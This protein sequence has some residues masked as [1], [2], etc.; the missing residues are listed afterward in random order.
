MTDDR[1]FAGL[2]SGVEHSVDELTDAI[3]GCFRAEIPAYAPLPSEQLEPGVRSNIQ[4]ALDAL[5]R[6]WEPT[7][8]EI[9]ASR[10]LGEE[11]ARQGVPLEALLRAHRI[12]VR[13]VLARVQS[14]A[15]PRA[16]GPTS[17]STCP[18]GRGHGPTP[19]C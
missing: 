15:R 19:S 12:G 7:S 13:E 4:R 6:G 1:A 14:D 18:R 8:A 5:Q 9:T 17:C 3:V 2:L 16:S 10:A 11:R